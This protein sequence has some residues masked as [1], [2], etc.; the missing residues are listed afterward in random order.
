ME[1]LSKKRRIISLVVFLLLFIFAV[2]I[3][4]A[5]S[6]GYR[7]N[8]TDFRIV[9]TGG[10]YI[11]SDL[12]D[13]KVFVDGV[14]Y[15]NSGTILRNTLIQRLPSEEVYTI[16]VEK[17]N[18]FPYYKDLFVDANM[19]TEVAVM[20]LPMEIPFTAIPATIDTLA[21]STI[22]RELP[23]DIF[24]TSSNLEYEQV[25]LLFSTSTEQKRIMPTVE[26]PT[27]FNKNA[28]S[29][30][31]VL[32]EKVV[33]LPEYILDLNVPEI[34]TKEK[35]KENGRLVTWLEYGDIHVM[36]AG[37]FEDTPY[38]FCDRRGCRDSI[39]VSTDTDINDYDYYPGRDD[40]LLI[41]T[42][43]DIFAIEI[44]DRSRNNLQPVFKGDEDPEFKVVGST[45]YVKDGDNILET[46]I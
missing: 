4:F 41:A 1:P 46:Q 44:D 23:S 5:Y 45:L 15:K 6:S 11:H 43:N 9:E 34:E 25:K 20:M 32:N 28:S 40:V 17:D 13:T 22:Q 36:W 29:T 42:A 3:L 26:I 8:F 33:L 39:I 16:R 38:Y 24:V 30:T 31:L 7:F 21:T 14:F 12:R 18:H 27:P 19:V 10:V 37:D 2:P 35:L